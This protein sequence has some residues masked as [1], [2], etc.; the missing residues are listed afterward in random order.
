M[1]HKRLTQD[2]KEVDEDERPAIPTM[3]ISEEK[4]ETKENG[5][6]K[7]SNHLGKLQSM[8]WYEMYGNKCFFPNFLIFFLLKQF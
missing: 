1:V 7:F 5:F 2:L 3:F 8:F 4:I 6:R